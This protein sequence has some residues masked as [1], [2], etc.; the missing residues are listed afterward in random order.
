MRWT[1]PVSRTLPRRR[2]VSSSKGG[3]VCGSGCED[4]CAGNG[5]LIQ[6]ALGVQGTQEG[7]GAQG[8]HTVGG[9]INEYRYAA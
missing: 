5:E 1:G 4:A 3:D 2:S 8:P 6:G 7:A 9:A